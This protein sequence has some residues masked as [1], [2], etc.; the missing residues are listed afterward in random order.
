MSAMRS[1]MAIEDREVIGK[2]V[3]RVLQPSLP[4]NMALFLVA[5]FVGLLYALLLPF[6][7]AA[8]LGWVAGKA[9]YGQPRV[10]KALRFG[11]FVAKLATAPLV[12]LAYLVLFP[13]IGAGMLVW[14]GLREAAGTGDAA[15]AW[16]LAR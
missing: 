16:A 10:R 13:F 15:G 7:G 5:P 6:V 9:L 1:V 2:S 8:M 4:R 11:R 3:G 12:G 14:L